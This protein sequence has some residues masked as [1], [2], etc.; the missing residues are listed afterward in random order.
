L[1]RAFQVKV[2]QDLSHRNPLLDQVLEDRVFG[3]FDVHLQEVDSVVPQ[4]LQRL[5]FCATTKTADGLNLWYQC[6]G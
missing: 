2:D 6:A 4:A 5:S 3:S 1:S